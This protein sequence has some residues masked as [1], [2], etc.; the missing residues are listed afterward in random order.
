M[1]RLHVTLCH[2][3]DYVGLPQAVV[4]R[5]R[6]AAET[7]TTPAFDVTFDRVLSFTGRARYRPFVLK[8]RQG[9]ATVEA[10]Q[11]QLGVAMTAAGLGKFA[12]PYTPHMTLLYDGAE[13]AEQQV[14]PIT[15]TV[16]EFT[17]VHSLLGQ[18]RHIPLGRWSL[19]EAQASEPESVLERAT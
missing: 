16:T 18:T 12:K 9:T 6:K 17:L 14:D 11:R 8:S 4:A 7:F 3:G 15:W 19:G 5:A 2:V 10:F 1:E 13:V